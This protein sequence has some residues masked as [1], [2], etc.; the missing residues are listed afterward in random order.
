M[1]KLWGRL[2]GRYILFPKGEARWIGTNYRQTITTKAAAEVAADVE[3]AEAVAEEPP[4]GVSVYPRSTE[5]A[6]LVLCV[7]KVFIS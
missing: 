3:E 6:R 2:N 4:R 5:G 7:V 1:R